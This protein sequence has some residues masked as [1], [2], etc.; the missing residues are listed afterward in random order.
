M[1]TP[2]QLGSQI[3]P[4]RNPF[5]EH[6]P[7]VI[8]PDDP[9]WGFPIAV[10]TWLT[11]LFILFFTPL[12]FVIPYALSRGPNTQSPDFGQA[13]VE[14]VTK[15]PTAIFLQVLSTLPAHL[16]T[17]LI[18]WF[19]VTKF[20]KYPFWETLGWSWGRQFGL[21]ACIGLGVG[22]FLLSA[23]IAELLG[24]NKPTQL[25]LIL[26]NSPATK[27][28]IAFLATFT[29][30]FAEE[31][32]YRGLLYSSLQRLIGQWKAVA[33]VLVL[34]TVIHVPQYQPNYGVIAAVGF[35]S[36]ALT[37]IRAV[38]GKLLPCVIIHLVF[39]G[40]QSILIVAGFAGPKP[41]VKPE[42]IVPLIQPLLRAL[43]LF[44]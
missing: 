12:V 11:S 29:A 6:Q 5:S 32:I 31:F 43:H 21:W 15:D 19:V 20:R 13:F 33:V 9:P 44:I 7:R 18:V 2:E 27:Y 38:S 39:N 30:P 34:F 25:D 17:F 41:S 42:Q 22:L 4:N 35:L 36:L 16:L 24:G 37:V 3:A 1:Q 23:A 14:F 26:N 8:D 10:L 28:L 40:I